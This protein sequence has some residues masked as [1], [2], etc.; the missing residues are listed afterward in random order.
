MYGL[1]DR[2]TKG[3]ACRQSG[4]QTGVRTTR[5]RTDM[6]M[7]RRTGVQWVDDN[8]TKCVIINKGP[9]AAMEP[10]GLIEPMGLVEPQITIYEQ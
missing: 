10:M 8:K 9:L 7:G 3:R 4:L 1:V 2:R 6:W 5:R